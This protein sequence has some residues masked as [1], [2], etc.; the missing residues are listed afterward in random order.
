MLDE[1]SVALD[2]EGVQLLEYII[3]EHRKRGGIVIVTTHLP[4]K[5]EDALRLLERFKR[6]E[7]YVEMLN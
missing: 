4:I 5:M 2:T 1:P 3:K 6:R 7:G